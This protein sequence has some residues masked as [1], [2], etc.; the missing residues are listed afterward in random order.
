MSQAWTYYEN[1][2]LPEEFGV[3]ENVGT[4]R[5]PKQVLATTTD[6]ITGEEVPEINAPSAGDL[7][8]A[9]NTIAQAQQTIS[10]GQT[11]L[12][13]LNSGII[14][15]GAVGSKITTA[16]SGMMPLFKIS[17]YEQRHHPR[18]GSWFENH[19]FL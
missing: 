14:P 7:A 15:D 1:V 10:E 5:F 9:R 18:W 19:H 8:T 6:P 12:D 2:Y 4:R 17:R 3:Y 13:I 16:P 11:Y